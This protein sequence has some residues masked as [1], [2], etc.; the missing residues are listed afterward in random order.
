MDKRNGKEW[1]GDVAAFVAWTLACGVVIAT[2][3]GCTPLQVAQSEQLACIGNRGLLAIVDATGKPVSTAGLAALGIEATCQGLGFPNG[4]S[5][6][7]AVAAAL[8]VA[9]TSAGSNAVIPPAGL[10][11]HALPLPPAAPR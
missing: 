8:P 9:G 11:E 7:P 1:A 4:A 3:A 10:S 6:T 2:V 5:V